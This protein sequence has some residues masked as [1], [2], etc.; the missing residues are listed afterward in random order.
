M[1]CNKCEAPKPSKHEMAWS[2]MKSVERFVIPTFKKEEKKSLV[3][4]PIW[5]S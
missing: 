2:D 1:F 5:K 3:Y 4:I